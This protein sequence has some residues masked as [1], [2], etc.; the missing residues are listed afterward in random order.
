MPVTFASAAVAPVPG[1]FLDKRRK[2]LTGRASHVDVAQ[3]AGDAGGRRGVARPDGE[4][5]AARGALRQWPSPGAAFPG[6]VADGDLRA[7]LLLGRG[8]RLLAAARRLYDGGG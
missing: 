7:R 4:N 1:R 2:S 8:A 5:A 3:E 6:R